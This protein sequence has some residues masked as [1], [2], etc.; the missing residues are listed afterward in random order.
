M[1]Q[2]FAVEP[3]ARCLTSD[4][5]W[6]QRYRAFILKRNRNSLDRQTLLSYDPALYFAYRL[7]ESH[8]SDPDMALIVEARLLSG[9]DFESIA[10]GMKTVPKTVE[11]YSRL[12]FDVPDFLTHKDWIVRQV[13]LP[14]ARRFLTSDKPEFDDYSPPL[15][16]SVFGLDGDLIDNVNRKSKKQKT[17]C[18]PFLDWTLKLFSYFGGPLVCDMMISGFQDR[19]NIEDPTKLSAYF[20]DQIV[21]Q[22]SRRAAQASVQFDINR[23]NIMELFQIVNSMVIS[24]KKTGDVEGTLSDTAELIG[25]IN[26][27]LDMSFGGVRPNGQVIEGQVKKYSAEP[28]VEEETLERMGK[29]SENL[30]K[31]RKTKFQELQSTEEE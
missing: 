9:M 12:F 10:H 8:L 27:Y 26:G 5:K 17:I 30:R 4:D 19:Q 31:A 15:Q 28:D 25:G 16:V 21:N 6:I 20:Q 2:M 29:T 1:Q 24:F 3:V 23:Y 7:Y 13:L 11:W 22:L 18:K 14:S